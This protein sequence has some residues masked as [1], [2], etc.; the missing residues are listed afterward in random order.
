MWKCGKVQRLASGAGSSYR[1]PSLYFYSFY[2]AE[3][4]EIYKLASGAGL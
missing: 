2:N 3:R 4:E 1:C